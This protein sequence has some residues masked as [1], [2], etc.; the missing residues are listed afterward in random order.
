MPNKVPFLDFR[1]MHDPLRDRIDGALSEVARS[2]YYIRGEKCDA[3]EREFA[4]YIGVKYCVGVGNGLDAIQ[5]ILRAM[6][7]GAGDEVIVPSNTYIATA[8]AVTY[9]GA[10]PVFVEPVL[11]TAEIDPSRIEAAIT[12]KTKAICVVHLQGRPCDMDPIREIADRHGLRLLEDCAQAHGA[13]YR[14]RRTGSL[15]EAGA[16]SFYPGKNLGALGDGGAVVTDDKDLAD[17]VRY[18]ANYGSDVKYHHIYKG[19]NSRLDEMQAAVLSVKLPYLD[20]WNSDRVKLAA[21]YRDAIK[22]SEV[23]LP[24]PPDDVFSPVYHVYGIRVAEGKRD[25]LA[26]YLKDQGVDTIMHYPTP[27]HLQGA[28]ADL[29]L[30]KGDLPIAEEFSATELSIPIFPGMTDEALKY[31]ADKINGFF[32]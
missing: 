1:P 14:G 27:M 8:L 3:F 23:A 22:A 20:E 28:Y 25:A 26:A 2:D 16:F 10:K 9:T 19:L 21:K 15:S 6:D 7:I 17:K 32:S 24:L 4:E 29:G 13:K 5:L 31:V 18:I 11:E 30:K 12:D